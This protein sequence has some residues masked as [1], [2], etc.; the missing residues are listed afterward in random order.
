MST[1]K[2]ALAAVALVAAC[3]GDPWAP[4]D[5]GGG[6]G[7]G[8]TTDPVPEEVS[9]NLVAISYDPADNGT[10]RV[11]LEGLTASSQ[12][13]AFL[14]APKLDIDGYQAFIYQETG[15]QRSHLALVATNERGTLEAYAVADGGQFNRHFGGARFAQVTAYRRP[16]VA[17]GPTPGPETGQFSYAGSYAGVF[18]PGDWANTTLPPGLRPSEPWRVRGDAL[19]NANFA[20]NL[21][22]GGVANRVLLDESGN[23]VT[24]I[25]LQDLALIE[26][27]IADDGTFLGDVEFA[28][29]PGGAI[30]NYAGAFGGN[31]ATDVAGV[32]VFNPVNDP[33]IWEYGVLNLPRCDLAGAS[34]LCVPR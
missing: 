15:L 8:G 6:G 19:I 18:V 2:M 22:N 3:G 29:A 13:V 24:S 17:Q 20:N 33:H 32:L 14:R 4:D 7:G 30:G 23:P 25:E 5:G 10:L 1:W 27:G 34:P 12:T 21:V 28:G 16:S 11:N 26:T 9:K 31:G